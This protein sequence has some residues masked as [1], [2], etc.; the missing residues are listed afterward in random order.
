MK[1]K[2]KKG[3]KEEERRR[4][5]KWG[6]QG[7]D[8]GAGSGEIDRGEREWLEREGERK[9]GR[10]GERVWHINNSGLCTQTLYPDGARIC[11]KLLYVITYKLVAIFPFQ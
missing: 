4:E 6:E 3:R 2:Y 5:G 11:Y 10:K 9:E 7:L 8:G 1:W